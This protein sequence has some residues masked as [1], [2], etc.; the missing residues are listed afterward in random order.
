LGE[1]TAL[2]KYGMN[3]REPVAEFGTIRDSV[4]ATIARNARRPR[5]RIESALTAGAT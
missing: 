2:A 3:A 1:I 5:A 4:S